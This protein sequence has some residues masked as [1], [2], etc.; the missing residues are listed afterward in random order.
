MTTFPSDHLERLACLML[1][2]LLAKR[3]E[4]RRQ[5]AIDRLK[6][7]SA[8]TPEAVGPW[9]ENALAILPEVARDGKLIT[10]HLHMMGLPDDPPAVAS[11]DDLMGLLPK[12][13]ESDAR[14]IEVAVGWRAPSC[15][16]E[17]EEATLWAQ[18]LLMREKEFHKWRT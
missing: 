1:T 2:K 15:D 11:V 18:E 13:S 4:D 3:T 6:A 17:L 7:L 14:S 8:A 16:E 10:A 5:F 9:T 12:A